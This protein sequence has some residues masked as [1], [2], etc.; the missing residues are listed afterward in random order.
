MSP[1]SDLS[2]RMNR[3]LNNSSEVSTDQGEAVRPDVSVVIV[4]YQTRELTLRCL[5]TLFENSET[6]ILETFVVDNASSDGSVEAVKQAFPRVTVIANESNLG[7]GA[8]N[9]VALK[10]ARGRSVLFLNSDAFVSP[11]AVKRLARV[12]NQSPKVGVVG[13]RILNNDGTVQNSVFPFPSPGR[14]LLVNF[15]LGSLLNQKIEKTATGDTEVPWVS[16]ACFMIRNEML[17]RVGAFDE[18]FFMYAEETDLQKRVRESGSQIYYVPNAEV[19]HLGGSSGAGDP[20]RVFGY[21]YQSHDMY[22]RKHFGRIGL[23]TLRSVMTLGC[24]VRAVVYGS[25]GFIGKRRAERRKRAHFH[26]RLAIRQCGLAPS[27]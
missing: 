9:N 8:A 27:R 12:L 6:V 19:I 10:R 25:L 18:R 23:L 15:G 16:G 5:K 7:F 1:P 3:S 13:P 20:Q 21:F 11:D 2:D 26:L 17:N 22:Y 24:A 4:S 14:L